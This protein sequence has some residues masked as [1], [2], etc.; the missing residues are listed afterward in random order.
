MFFVLLDTAGKITNLTPAPN[1]DP[2]E[3]VQ[4]GGQELFLPRYLIPFANK[5]KLGKENALYEM[6]FEVIIDE[7]A[8]RQSHLPNRWLAVST[9]AEH[10]KKWSW[11][12]SGGNKSRVWSA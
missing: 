11:V 8:S 5:V 2:S 10:R 3:K 12:S 1:D 7:L 9:L 6:Y 4:T